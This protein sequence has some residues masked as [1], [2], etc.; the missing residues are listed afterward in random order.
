MVGLVN[1]VE[2][3][4]LS[5]VLVLCMTLF[6]FSN[7]FQGGIIVIIIVVIGPFCLHVCVPTV[8]FTIM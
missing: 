3:Y 4:L 8:G 2:M 5:I 6:D 1:L 7:S